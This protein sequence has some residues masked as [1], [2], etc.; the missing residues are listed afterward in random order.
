MYPKLIKAEAVA[1]LILK[2]EYDSGEIKQINM[3]KYCVT[4]F[5]KQLEIWDYFKLVQISGSTVSWPNEQDLAPE[6][7]YL[8]SELIQ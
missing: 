8:E 1:P 3:S 4:N 2:I 6:T 7:L 5:F